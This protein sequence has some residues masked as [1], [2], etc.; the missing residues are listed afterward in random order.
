MK[1]ARARDNLCQEVYVNNRLV[2]KLILFH[3]T[4]RSQGQYIQEVYVNSRL[5]TKLILFHETGR[6]QGQFMSGGLCK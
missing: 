3:E 1:Q 6:S 4:G 2:T 5:V